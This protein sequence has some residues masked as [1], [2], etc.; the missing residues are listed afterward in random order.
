MKAPCTYCWSYSTMRA[1]IGRHPTF[2]QE[3][4]WGHSTKA[5]YQYP[6]W[7]QNSLKIACMFWCLQWILLQRTLSNQEE[8]R[9]SLYLFHVQTSTYLGELPYIVVMRQWWE[10]EEKRGGEGRRKEGKGEKRRGGK[11][12]EQGK[13][14]KVRPLSPFWFL[15]GF[16]I[17]TFSLSF[18]HLQKLGNTFQTFH[19]VYSSRVL[20]LF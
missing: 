8:V 17:W 1:N 18:L 7:S 13:K 14:R 2:S 19:S 10:G 4:K 3:D 20:T 15:I 12:R 5:R 9:K 11:G 6:H 16:D